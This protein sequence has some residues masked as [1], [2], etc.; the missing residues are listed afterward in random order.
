MIGWIH[1]W[2]HLSL[3]ISILEGILIIGSIYLIDKAYQIVYF[4]S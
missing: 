1:Q 4:L 2:N 3:K